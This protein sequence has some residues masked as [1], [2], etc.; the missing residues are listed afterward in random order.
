MR[1]FL[2]F[3]KNSVNQAIN[4][5][6]EHEYEMIV[7]TVLEEYLTIT[8][9][10]ENHVENNRILYMCLSNHCWIIKSSFV[11]LDWRNDYMNCSVKMSVLLEI[12]AKKDI[13]SSQYGPR[14]FST[15]SHN[16]SG[17]IRWKNL[18]GTILKTCYWWNH[19]QDSP[20]GN[21]FN[22]GGR[23]GKQNSVNPPLLTFYRY[24]YSHK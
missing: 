16:Y 18:K 8:F 22:G 13:C 9:K 12:I 17:I 5:F 21:V 1:T 14:K 3:Y 4:H 11:R 15:R 10:T 6:V 20:L 24:T 7:C 23:K 2:F 19:D